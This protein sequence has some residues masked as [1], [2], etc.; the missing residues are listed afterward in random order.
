MT[1]IEG[2]VKYIDLEGGFWGIVTESENYYPIHFHEQL[3]QH[4]LHLSCSIVKLNV[5]TAQNWGI[6][7][8]IESFVT[9]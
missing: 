9:P 8:R 6:P 4:G 3:K 7:C 1:K 2:T 5:M